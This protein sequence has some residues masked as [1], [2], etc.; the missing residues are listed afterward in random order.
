MTA[1]GIPFDMVVVG[2]TGDLARRKLLPAL[3]ILH[4]YQA[5][6]PDGRIVEIHWALSGGDRWG[7]LGEP[8]TPVIAPAV[9]NALYRIT[10]RRI[11]SVA[12]MPLSLWFCD[13]S[14]IGQKTS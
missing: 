13:P 14:V 10:G 3:Y 4:K 1:S 5:L 11:R 9:C 7:G 12:T 2:A 8:T 6:H